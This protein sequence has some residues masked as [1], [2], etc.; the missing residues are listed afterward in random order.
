M[1]KVN[2]DTFQFVYNQVVRINNKI[3][4]LKKD[5][6]STEKA[7]TGELKKRLNLSYLSHSFFFL[8]DQYIDSLTKANAKQNYQKSWNLYKKNPDSKIP[9]FHKK[10]YTQVYQTNC[11]YP[12]QNSFAL[13]C[14]SAKF[15]DKKHLKLPKI[16]KIRFNKSQRTLLN[17]PYPIRIGTVTIRKDNLDRF[18]V[19]LQLGSDYPFVNKVKITGKKVGIDLNTSNF[20]TDSNGQ[21]VPN[22]R[23]YRLIQ[24]KLKRQSRKLAKRKTRA[25]KEHRNLTQSSNYQK[26]RLL[27]ARIQAKVKAQRKNFLNTL[28]TILI[29]NHDLIVAEEL[30]SK[31]LL[32]N[33]HLALSI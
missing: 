15:I 24:N 9:T 10:N 1:I 23:Y 28:S 5:K 7:K 31:N 13:T 3:Y 14:G 6:S 33:H 19:S 16:G 22:P 27:V 4:K 11:Q 21:L 20:L 2:S 18:F 8:K 25:K 26:Q 29:K 32:K 17:R 30:R 12:G